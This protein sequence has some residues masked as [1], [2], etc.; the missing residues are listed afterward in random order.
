LT[1]SLTGTYFVQIKLYDGM[2]ASYYNL[3][4]V[5]ASNTAPKFTA[6]IPVNQTIKLNEIRSY[7]LPNYSDAEGNNITITL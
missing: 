1:L 3:T 7:L 4:I 2:L 5:I 6:N